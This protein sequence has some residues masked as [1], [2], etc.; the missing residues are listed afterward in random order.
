MTMVDH[1]IETETHSSAAIVLTGLSLY[2]TDLFSRRSKATFPELITRYGLLNILKKMKP[3]G[4]RWVLNKGNGTMSEPHRAPYFSFHRENDIH[5][6]VIEIWEALPMKSWPGGPGGK[7]SA[8]LWPL[9]QKMSPP[10][11]I[12]IAKMIETAMPVVRRQEVGREMLLWL[13]TDFIQLPIS[14]IRRQ[15]DVA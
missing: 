5:C 1:D 8:Y 14:T 13:K 3:P 12:V 4:E 2:I 10:T 9:D 6:F 11:V 7:G 15:T